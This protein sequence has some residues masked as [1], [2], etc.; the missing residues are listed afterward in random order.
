[1]NVAPITKETTK[2]FQALEEA[3]PIPAREDDGKY[4]TLRRI[5]LRLVRR[6]L[7]FC[8]Q[9]HFVKE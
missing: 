2:R 1:M 7:D 8:V 5:R 6:K 3:P 4:S 9:V